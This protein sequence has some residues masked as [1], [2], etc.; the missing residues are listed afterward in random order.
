MKLSFFI[1]PFIAIL[2]CISCESNHTKPVIQSCNKII[3]IEDQMDIQKQDTTTIKQADV[4]IIFRDIYEN[5]LV[6]GLG[7]AETPYESFKNL[8]EACG[9]KWDDYLNGVF[10]DRI[11]E[12]DPFATWKMLSTKGD[13]FSNIYFDRSDFKATCPI[14]FIYYLA[15][16]DEGIRSGG[17]ETIAKSVSLANLFLLGLQLRESYITDVET[18]FYEQ[19]AGIM[20]NN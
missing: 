6:K 9:V 3:N 2:F 7:M 5:G 10:S 8:T 4:W 13:V 20:N 18:T 16:I 1:I 15:G 19:N 17:A 14:G 11:T 12:V